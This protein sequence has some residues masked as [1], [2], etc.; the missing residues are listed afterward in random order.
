MVEQFNV[1]MVSTVP[2]VRK[3]SRILYE[4]TISDKKIVYVY[5]NERIREAEL[6]DVS[7]IGTKNL[8]YFSIFGSDEY[9]LIFERLL[10]SIS[11]SSNKSL[12]DLM[13]ITDTK[14][15]A[16]IEALEVVSKFPVF[17][18]FLTETPNDGVDA[19]IKKLEIFKYPSINQY[20]KILFLDCDMLATSP[21]E[22]IFFENLDPTKIEIAST[23]DKPLANI[24]NPSVFH[25]LDYFSP[26]N[27]KY[28]QENPDKCH[29][30]NAGQFL[31]VNSL[32]MKKHFENVQWLMSVWPGEYYFEQSFMNHYFMLNGFTSSRVLNTKIAFININAS[33]QQVRTSNEQKTDFNNIKKQNNAARPGIIINKVK[34][35][36]EIISS[37]SGQT[38]FDSTIF[39]K[40][41]DKI[42]TKDYYLMHFVGASTNGEL[43]LKHINQFIID[44]NVCQ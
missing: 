9:V 30:I 12:F 21:I 23:W 43:K 13:V 24:N 27:I 11:A 34:T 5:L 25:V 14:T 33:P 41:N 26:E 35:K 22:Q 28:L 8:I 44:K 31:F 20:A 32:R 2:F 40:V 39:K 17:D 16:K 1:Y 29:P 4:D 18:Y 38:N 19:S 15:K 10:K 36:T 3:N 7:A 42:N 6:A 37:I